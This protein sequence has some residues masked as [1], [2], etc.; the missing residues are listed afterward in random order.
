[1]NIELIPLLQDNYAYLLSAD[2][3]TCA[4]VDPSVG[5]DTISFLN[6][7]DIKPEYVLNTHHHWDHTGGNAE[8]KKA[9]GAKIAGPIAD[10]H[11]IEDLD[12]G[13]KE[14]DVFK[15]GTSEARII[16]TPGHTSGHICFHF[17]KDQALFCGD[18]LFLMGCGRLFEGTAEQMWHSLSKILDLPDETKIY[19]GHEYT[20]ANAEF[21][22]TIEPENKD[23]IARIEEVKSLRNQNKP[24]IPA[25][26]ELEKRTNAFLRAGSAYRFG[27]IRALKDAA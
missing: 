11:R 5:K 23:L 10:A 14:N 25:T 17:E 7:R 16:E 26:L 24:T 2:D 22:L 21:C 4:I 18:T 13:L 19:C 3:G 20:L 27:E 1:M 8:L 15:L 9:F 12:I 6:K